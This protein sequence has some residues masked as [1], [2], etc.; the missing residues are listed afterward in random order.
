VAT[1][2]EPIEQLER[3]PMQPFGIGFEG[4]KQEGA[5]G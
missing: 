2:I 1:A 5:E 4:G 3:S